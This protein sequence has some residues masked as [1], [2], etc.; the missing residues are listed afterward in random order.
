VNDLRH[1]KQEARG[2]RQESRAWRLDTRDLR[3]K[4]LGD[5]E[6]GDKNQETRAKKQ[7]SRD[8]RQTIEEEQLSNLSTF[9]LFNPY[10]KK[11]L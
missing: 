5:S 11:L 7:E 1:K 3:R 10:A 9:P 2:K 8:K 6:I 4:I